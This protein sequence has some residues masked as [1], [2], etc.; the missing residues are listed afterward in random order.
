VSGITF[1]GGV[2]EQ[3]IF[4]PPVLKVPRECPLVLLVALCLREREAS[5]NK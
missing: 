3:E 5:G 4:L 2:G 1:G